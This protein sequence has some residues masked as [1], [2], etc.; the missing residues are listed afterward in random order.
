MTLAE[1]LIG[2]ALALGKTP[3]DLLRG[4]GREEKVLK[5]AKD[6]SATEALE[7]ATYTAIE[8]LARAVVDD[9]TAELAA[10]IR[11]DEERM[12]ARILREIPKLTAAVVGADVGGD[13]SYDIASTGARLSR[14]PRWGTLPDVPSIEPDP[15]ALLDVE[16]AHAAPRRI[17]KAGAALAGVPLALYVVDLDGS[18]AVRIAGEASVFPER[19]DAPLGIGPELA[20]DVLDELGRL[21]TDVLAG[22]EV[23]PLIVRDRAL[24]FLVARHAPGVDLGPFALQAALALE[25]VSGYTDVVHSARRRK[26]VAAAAEIQENLLPP[27][28]ARL[29]GAALAGGVLPGYEVGGDFFDHASNAEGVWLMV[30]DATGKGNVAAALSSLGLGA[31]R[32]ARRSGKGL[33]HTA[34]EIDATV[35]SLGDP[36]RF[37]TLLL[38]LWDPAD[39]E[40]RWL[41]CGHP[42]PLVARADGTVEELGSSQTYPLGA[43]DAGREF[44]PARARLE[45]GDRLVLY[46]DGVSERRLDGG[47]FFG[48]DGIRAVLGRPGIEGAAAT[49]RALQDAVID[50]SAGPMR[51]DATLLVLARDR[52][53][54]KGERAGARS[55]RP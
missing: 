2:Q 26:E 37:L 42:P 21:V 6:A 8:R 4:S 49:V 1:S 11:A 5:N 48:V 55:M 29:E 39:G 28:I 24:G 15:A 13:G 33:A 35:R 51:D 30:A 16:P 7:V 45:P 44:M 22:C 18:A 3:L 47:S 10:S 40:L 46:S 54:V 25:L 38:A 41:S 52:P 19:I 9:E 20:L 27:R 32:A 12:L 43:L 34:A 17:I 14:A 53:R 23:V 50:A 31:A 36:E